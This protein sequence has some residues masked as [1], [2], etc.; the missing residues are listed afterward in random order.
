MKPGHQEQNTI[1]FLGVVGRRSVLERQNGAKLIKMEPD[2]PTCSSKDTER[3]PKP[4]K[5]E[6][7]A[8]KS[9]P[10]WNLRYP[11]CT[12]RLPKI[13]NDVQKRL[14]QGCQPELGGLPPEH[15]FF[16]FYEE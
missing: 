7:N 2:G 11:K 14:V 12:K 4:F 15:I 5:M 8:I 10:K 13:K 3:E 9:D 16:P 6:T 1:S